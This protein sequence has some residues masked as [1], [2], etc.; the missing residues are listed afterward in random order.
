MRNNRTRHLVLLAIW[1]FI[2]SFAGY[3]FYVGIV[4]GGISFEPN[5]VGEPTEVLYDVTLDQSVKSITIDWI[6]GGVKIIPTNDDSIRIVEKA[7]EPV[8][9]KKWADVTVLGT[10]L[11]IESKNKPLFFFMGLMTRSTYLEVYLPITTSLNSLK[12][13]GVS[14]N[15]SIDELYSDLT[16]ITLTSGNLTIDNS[17]SG[18]LSLT[19]TSGNSTITDSQIL[20]TNITMTSGRLDYHA[21][22]INFNAE[23]TSGL[24][25]LRF[26]NTNPESLSLSMT[27][28]SSNIQLYGQTAFSVSVDK[29]SGSFNPN[30]SYV[31]NGSVYSYLSGGPMY[32]IDMTSGA[33]D[34]DLSGQ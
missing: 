15:Y 5:H 17:Y 1:L 3:F 2:G 8:D 4:Q 12:L 33:V 16:Q 19:M 29:T 34:L 10:S 26:G 30:F 13:V 23:M 18:L 25:N 11:T 22:T 21:D 14:G 32:T 20:S 9:K 24:A 31:K 7:Y 27:S 6:S 28:G